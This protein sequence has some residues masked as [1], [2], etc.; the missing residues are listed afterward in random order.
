MGFRFQTLDSSSLSEIGYDP[1]TKL[2]AARFTSGTCY[3]YGHVPE[4][5]FLKVVGAG[6][7]GRS[8][9]ALVK[10]GGFG[11]RPISDAEWVSLHNTPSPVPTVSPTFVDFIAVDGDTIVSLG[12]DR[13][14][15]ALLVR[16]RSGERII[17]QGL[18]GPL[19][20]RLEKDP[21]QEVVYLQM[22]RDGP[23]TH[24]PVSEEQWDA[25]CR[26]PQHL[27]PMAFDGDSRAVFSW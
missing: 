24:W 15:G 21:H 9:D 5:I 27:T 4:D 20:S 2:L 7:V 10:K 12:F 3:V 17:H 22:L 11:C 19:L 16:F 1:D 8:F 13:L 26:T 23:G 18:P 14:C 25:Y 6:S